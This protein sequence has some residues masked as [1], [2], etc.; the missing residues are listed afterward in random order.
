MEVPERVRIDE[1]VYIIDDE[2]RGGT[3]HT[4]YLTR[5][6]ARYMVKLSWSSFDKE[7]EKQELVKNKL[8]PYG[9]FV[10]T[11]HS[12]GKYLDTDFFFVKMDYL[13]PLDWTPYSKTN[14][15]EQLKTD[16]YIEPIFNS[17]NIDP[18]YDFKGYTG[19]HIFIRNTDGKIGLIDF[20]NYSVTN[21]RTNKRRKTNNSK[22]SKN[23]TVSGLGTN[24]RR[25]TNK[26]RRPNKKMR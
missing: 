21:N 9:I 26:R 2:R 8:E 10:P 17:T 24:K 1:E 6:D 3:S 7:I 15:D 14:P 12:S 18:G 19:D 4:Y 11:I 23:Y 16:K 20:Q 13:N 5:D 22:N 25:K